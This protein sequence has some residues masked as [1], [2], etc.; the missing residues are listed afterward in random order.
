MSKASR[1]R[2]LATRVL[3][4]LHLAQPAFRI[5]ERRLASR[6]VGAP[7]HDADGLPIPPARM[8]VEVALSVRPEMLQDRG[9]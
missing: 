3:D 4:R 8:R 9:R 2:L 7:E 5:Y 6:A 1:A